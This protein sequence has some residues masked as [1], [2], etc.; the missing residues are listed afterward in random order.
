MAPLLTRTN[1]PDKLVK[2]TSGG[3][4]MVAGLGWGGTLGEKS[5]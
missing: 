1:L 3:L 5:D 2:V 4:A